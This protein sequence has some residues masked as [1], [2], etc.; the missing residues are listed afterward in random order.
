MTT[1]TLNI[2]AS[3]ERLIESTTRKALERGALV[4]LP[5]DLYVVE[6]SGI[7]FQIRVAD[8]QERK[9]RAQRSPSDEPSNPFLPPDEDLVVTKPGPRHVAVLNK[10]NVLD[11]HLLIVTRDFEPQDGFVD[12]DDLAALGR[13]MREVDGLGF[14]NGGE[15]AGASQPHKHL[16]L[17]PVPLGGG[18]LPT[19]L[20]AV[21][22][23]SPRAGRLTALPE[24]DFRHALAPLDG[25]PITDDQQ[26]DILQLFSSL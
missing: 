17:V 22:E 10:F 4:S 23:T 13:C 21:I 19:P 1:G 9:A 16:Q 12:R 18:S 8:L 24:L 11:H 2:V 15:I 6:D 7:P 5:T 20:D 25:S 14:Y 3:L 26:G